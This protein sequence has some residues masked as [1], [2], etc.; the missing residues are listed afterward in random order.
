MATCSELLNA[1]VPDNAGEDSISFLPALLGKFETANR[2]TIVNHSS[3]GRFAIREGAW[4]LSLCPGSGGWA[5]PKDDDAI[6]QGLPQLQLHDLAKDPGETTNLQAT[7]PDIVK[8]LKARLRTEIN[9]GR[10]TPGT[11][12]PN[13]VPIKIEALASE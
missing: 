12:Q 5:L 1:R 9:N 6:Q 3:T 13:D 11:N 10:S 8:R 2:P 7:H 4:K